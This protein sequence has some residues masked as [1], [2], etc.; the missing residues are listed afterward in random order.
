M[1]TLEP[2]E[3]SERELDILRLVATGASNKEIAQSLFI[4][5]NTVKVHLR[6]IFTKIGANSRTEAAMYAVH[7]KIVETASA[8]VLSG[9]AA[10]QS[11]DSA[12]L[13][14]PSTVLWD[15]KTAVRTIGL[16]V[17]LI[18]SLAIL[19]LV[20]FRDRIIPTEAFISPTATARVQWFQLPGLPTPR[21]GLAVT[22]YENQIYA[23]G[24]EDASGV[25]NV[26]ERYDPPTNTWTSLNPKPT[27]VTDISAAAIG[28]LIYVP[29]GKL[30]SGIVT[31]I[32]EIYDPQSDK[33]TTGSALPK[34]LS[35]H[36][37]AVFEGRIYL[38][39][40]WDGN[41]VVNDAYVFDPRNN[42]WMDLPSMP[43]ARSRA[44]AV[45]VSGKI[46]VIG[47]WDGQKGLTVNEVFQPDRSDLKS[48]WSEGVPLPSGRYGMGITNLADIIF[49]VGGTNSADDLTMI[50][51]E[52]EDKNWGQLEAPLQK[53]W[54]SLGSVTVGTRLYALGGE[55]EEGLANTMWSYQAIFTIILP[56]IQ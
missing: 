53:G 47:G 7:N 2:N 27:P 12:D 44:G 45:A 23:I 35:A 49:V 21:A 14:I 51:M 13:S 19:G 6:N 32:T 17:A 31:D 8:E 46:Y 4:S 1:P 42:T 48:Q 39:G 16:S 25:S 38:F 26:V 33:W 56:I 40:G 10:K 36:A 52:P 37:I 5:S 41:Q 28:G 22:N 20:Y 34:P 11:S 15:R 54:S 50:A 55:A 18:L 30:A 43:T 29:G 24:G 3:L 9:E